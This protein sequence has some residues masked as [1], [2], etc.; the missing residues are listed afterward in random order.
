MELIEYRGVLHGIERQR[1]I[2]LEETDDP[3]QLLQRDLG[4]NPRRI[5]QIRPRCREQRRH[6][7]L[8]RDHRF[9]PLVL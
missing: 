8:A 6:L 7:P 9:Q 3:R 1:H 5:L 2:M 4:I